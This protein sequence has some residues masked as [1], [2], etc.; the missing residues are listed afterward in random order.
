MPLKVYDILTEDEIKTIKRVRFLHISQMCYYLQI[1]R[2]NL[3]ERY[4]EGKIPMFKFG[5]QWRIKADD[6]LNI[7][8]NG[9][10]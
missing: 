3:F 10:I 9:E 2:S 8:L 6:F 7:L 4:K 5:H 1:C